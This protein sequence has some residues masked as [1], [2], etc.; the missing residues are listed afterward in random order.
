[1]QNSISK[2]TNTVRFNRSRYLRDT[3][4]EKMDTKEYVEL[5]NQR[6]GIE[7]LPSVFRR[8]YNVDNMPVRGEVCSKFYFGFKALATTFKRLL[9][10]PVMFN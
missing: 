2:K 10:S 3:I 9:N 8:K 6:A 4:R 7:G 5:T 1:M